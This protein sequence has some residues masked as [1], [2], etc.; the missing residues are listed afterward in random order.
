MSRPRS[1]RPCVAGP[2]RCTPGSE[3][4]RGGALVSPL[5]SQS[6]PGGA[7]VDAELQIG[8]SHAG[9]AGAHGDRSGFV[10]SPSEVHVPPPVQGR[11]RVLQLHPARPPA[12]TNHCDVGPRSS[13]AWCDFAGGGSR[14]DA[15][16]SD[17]AQAQ[18][19]VGSRSGPA[20]GRAGGPCAD[21]PTGDER[22]RGSTHPRAGHR[23]T[24]LSPAWGSSLRTDG[25]DGAHSPA[26]PRADPEESHRHPSS[27]RRRGPDGTSVRAGAGRTPRAR[28]TTAQ[29]HTGGSRRSRTPQRRS[30]VRRDA[31]GPRAP[32]CAGP[33]VRGSADR[34][35]RSR[36]GAS[37]PRPSS[38]GCSSWPCW[39]W[40]RASTSSSRETGATR[41]W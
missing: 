34:G 39:P 26:V 25:T 13:A 19:V 40:V 11:A 37:E 24:G 17:P 31:E 23:L 20:G 30:P 1:L 33:F 4:H 7:A 2:G 32:W 28:R 8:A 22:I 14:P 36:R 5:A 10:M 27:I 41:S 15:G 18:V 21:K 35:Q 38:T 6:G 29:A 3:H 9:T 16:M 12:A